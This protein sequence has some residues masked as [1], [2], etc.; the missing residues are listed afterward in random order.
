MRLFQIDRNYLGPMK[1]WPCIREVFD[2]ERI[3]TI[4]EFRQNPWTYRKF[5]LELS[6]AINKWYKSPHYM[7]ATVIRE[8]TILII[9][10]FQGR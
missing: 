5:H 3:R 4:R 6:K 8:V 1:E 9:V 7:T 2:M 10:T